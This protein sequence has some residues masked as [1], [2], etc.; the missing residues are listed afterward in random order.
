MAVTAP[1]LVLA[2]WAQHWIRGPSGS[3]A[4][5]DTQT[6]LLIGRPPGVGV[7][8][9]SLT[10]LAG[11]ADG[12]AT[13]LFLPVGTV[14][15]LPGLGQDRLAMAY[16]YGGAALVEATIENTMRIDVDHTSVLEDSGLPG[17][18]RGV[19]QARIDLPEPLVQQGEPELAS[20]ARSESV[21]RALLASLEDRHTREAVIEGG[22]PRLGIDPVWVAS[23]FA[24]LAEA[25]TDKRVHF[26]LLPVRPLANQESYELQREAVRT[27]VE[28]SLGG[29]NPVV[30]RDGVVRVQVLDAVGRPEVP[31]QVERALDSPAFHVSLAG[32]ARSFDL[33][34]TQIVVYGEETASMS[35]AEQVRQRLGVGTIQV[36]RQPQ[37][38]VDLT[39]VVGADFQPR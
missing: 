26:T 21:F 2:F 7:P 39:V 23:L 3:A 18:V 16:R 19:E 15:E 10:L 6:L 34:R 17:L 8:A 22:A 38:V 36:S 37:D 33:E 35:A 1:I 28:R 31:S 4:S 27:L 11:T 14:M 9:T 30:E 25:S 12:G 24:R 5:D 29:P 13:V 20:L 32:N